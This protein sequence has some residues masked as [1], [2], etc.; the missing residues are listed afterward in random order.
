MRADLALDALQGVVD[1]LAV[2]VEPARH[3]FVGM[4]VEVE[5]QHDDGEE[6]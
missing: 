1:R 4:A 6:T 5:R 3:L 2:A